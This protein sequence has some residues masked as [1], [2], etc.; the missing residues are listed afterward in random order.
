VK[1]Y[2][3]QKVKPGMII[4]RQRGSKFFAGLNVKKGGDDTLY[5]M[6]EGVIKFGLKKKTNFDGSKRLVKTV[7]VA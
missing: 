3:G 2:A 6:K 1:L 7:N 5:A 4:V